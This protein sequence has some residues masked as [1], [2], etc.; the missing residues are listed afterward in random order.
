MKL[1]LALLAFPGSCKAFQVNVDTSDEVMKHLPKVN[2][3]LIRQNDQVDKYLCDERAWRMNS[4]PNENNP[5]ILLHE[6]TF[7]LGGEPIV[8]PDMYISHLDI[9]EDLLRQ[10]DQVDRYLN[11]DRI[12]LFHHD[13]NN[14][15][16]HRRTDLIEPYLYEERLMF[17]PPLNLKKCDMVKKDNDRYVEEE[18]LDKVLSS[19]NQKQHLGMDKMKKIRIDI[20]DDENTGVDMVM[21]DW[22]PTQREGH[23]VGDG[24]EIFTYVPSTDDLHG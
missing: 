9:E 14:E 12:R 10:N 7:P 15:R 2:K 8:D 24:H 18:R 21:E 11:E 5:A 3:S 16:L 23:T 4:F 6:D 1:S 13:I 22:K 19:E 17:Q 20:L